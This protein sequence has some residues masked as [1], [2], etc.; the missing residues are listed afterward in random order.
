MDNMDNTAQNKFNLNFKIDDNV[1]VN[2]NEL[3][4]YN[5]DFLGNKSVCDITYVDGVRVLSYTIPATLPL[6]Q[7]LSKQLYKGEFLSIISNIL[8][9][10]L[11]FE[12]NDMALKKVMLNT[13]YMYIEL[14]NL[15]VQ[16]IY[17]PVEKNFADCNVCEFIQKFIEK[18]RFAD[19][20]CV[21]C[22]DQILSYLDSRMMFSLKDFY[23]FILELQKDNILNDDKDSGDGETTVLNQI[24]YKNIVPYLVRLRT[25]ELVPI[26]KS[27][28]TVGKSPD[29]NYQIV[30][31]KRISRQ[32]CSLKISNGECYI[33]DNDSTNKTY[34]NGKVIQPGFDVMLSN[35][36]YIRMADEEFKYWVR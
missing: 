24:Q 7:F 33:K 36:D 31:N 29:N 34:V 23:N 3:T 32:H 17:M 25:N 15:D 21:S 30:D 10:L 12:G 16:L 28:F 35:D 22:V 26:D 6:S 11:Y 19:M 8:K 1:S 4:L 14:Y 20:Q 9:Q 5:Y 18:V 13:K 2:Q 27:P